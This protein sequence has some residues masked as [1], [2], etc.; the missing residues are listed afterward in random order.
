[1][2]SNVSFIYVKIFNKN[3]KQKANKQA[4]KGTLDSLKHLYN[5]ISSKLMIIKIQL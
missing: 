1:M 3:F 5:K 2:I 4:L